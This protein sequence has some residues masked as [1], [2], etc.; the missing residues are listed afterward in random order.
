MK[1]YICEAVD[2]DAPEPFNGLRLPY[3]YIEDLVDVYGDIDKSSSRLTPSKT[4]SWFVDLDEYQLGRFMS[5]HSGELGRNL[6]LNWDNL[7]SF[8]K[9]SFEEYT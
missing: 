7:H 6:S 3:A 4:R 9:F 5:H 8:F 1:I 2:D